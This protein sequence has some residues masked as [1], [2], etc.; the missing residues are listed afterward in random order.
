MNI[1][2]QLAAHQ[3]LTDP[4]VV[5]G[6][7]LLLDAL[8][9]H[10][11][12]ITAI[13]PPI[14]GLKLSYEKSMAQYSKIRG[15]DLWH[16]YL[17]SGIGNGALVELADGSIK[18]DFISGIGVHF[19]GHSHPKIV[20][21]ALSGAFSDI[22]MQG[23]LQQNMESTQL[24][25][26][27]SKLS[28]LP[29]CYLSS[30][31]S[32][33]VENALK[34]A[35]QKQFPANRILTFERGFS[36]RTLALAQI[37]DKPLLRQNLPLTCAVDYIPF[38]DALRPEASTAA[39]IAAL[40]KVIKRYPK[41]HALMIFELIQGEGGCYPGSKDFFASLMSILKAH[42]IAIIVDEVQTFGRT[43]ELF[44]FQY[45][46]LQEYVDICAIGKLS[47]I[48]ATLFTEAFTPRIGLLG[49]TFTSSSTAI[50]SAIAMIKHLIEGNF[51]G[52]DG[53]IARLHAYFEKKL[54]DIASRHPGLIAGPFGMGGLIGFTVYNGEKEATFSFL[55]ALFEAGV[56]AF[57]AG[58]NPTRVRFLPPMGVIK[59]QEIDIVMHI[60]ES[61]LLR[62]FKGD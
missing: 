24:A 19:L 48:C 60:V 6:K 11:Q 16:P 57:F 8:K 13:R 32:M 46:D 45:F 5:Q 55:R 27:L 14:A 54:H 56:I 23:H 51:Y 53:K 17:G 34:I 37:S 29:H 1:S 12:Q 33:A 41:Q 20:E 52:P 21:A 9:K 35:F 38:F 36:G 10:Q 40:K 47:Q 31:G 22:V 26:L 42:A 18:Y 2:E 30:S 58:E 3:L 49:Q 15:T 59:E 25:A 62:L 7:K 50:Q 39:S 44:A 28:N 4:D 61:V 43:T